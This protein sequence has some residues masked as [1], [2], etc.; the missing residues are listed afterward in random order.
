MSLRPVEYPS[1]LEVVKSAASTT[2]IIPVR[3]FVLVR[4]EPE[5]KCRNFGW[6]GVSISWNF[7]GLLD[8]KSSSERYLLDFAIVPGGRVASTAKR[9]SEVWVSPGSPF[10]SW[11]DPV[12]RSSNNK[13]EN[14]TYESN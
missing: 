4:N 1:P 5:A 3:F 9:L 7:V 12:N 6:P 2:N 8:S 13:F 14:A 11:K 10:S